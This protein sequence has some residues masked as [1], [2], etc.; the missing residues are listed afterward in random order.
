M[1]L[2]SS[3]RD[4]VSVKLLYTSDEQWK[5]KLKHKYYLQYHQKHRIFRGKAHKICVQ[6]MK[7]VKEGLNKWEYIPYSW[8]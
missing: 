4:K 7:K 3:Q 5:L 8:I 1:G 6:D 2:A